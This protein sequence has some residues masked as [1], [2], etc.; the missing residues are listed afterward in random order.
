MANCQ[1]FA[2]Y[3]G[4][5]TF[6]DEQP[7]ENIALGEI[8]YPGP[9]EVNQDTINK[10]ATPLNNEQNQGN[11]NDN[12]LSVNSLDAPLPVYLTQN[13]DGSNQINI[14]YPSPQ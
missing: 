5:S 14:P 2:Y 12:R 9:E 1:Q 11:D 8:A 13:N 3:D 4:H 6:I 7:D 10:P